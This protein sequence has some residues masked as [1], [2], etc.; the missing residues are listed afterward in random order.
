[1]FQ[2]IQC[3]YVMLLMAACWVTEALLLAITSLLHVVL[4]HFVKN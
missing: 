3:A 1:V 4:F 2:A